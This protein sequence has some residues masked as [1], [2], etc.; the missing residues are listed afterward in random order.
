M[1]Q[2]YLEKS[3]LE[4]E[5]VE[6]IRQRTLRAQ[7]EFAALEKM[8]NENRKIHHKMKEEIRKMDQ[9]IAE[10]SSFIKKIKG[11]DPQQVAYGKTISTFW[12]TSDVPSGPLSGKIASYPS[13]ESLNE[14]PKEELTEAEY[15]YYD[16]KR[17]KLMGKMALANDVYMAHLQNFGQEDPKEKSQRFLYQFNEIGYQLHRQFD[18]VAERLKLPFEQPLMTYP[19]LGNL[20]DVIQ[21]EDM[22][23]KNREYF[24]EMAKEVKVKDEI[25]RKVLNNRL[26]IVKTPQEKDKTYL[27]YNEYRKESKRLLN[28]CEKMIEKREKG[29]DSLEL[30]QPEGVPEVKEIPKEKLDEKIK[31]IIGPPQ[32]V[33]PIG[34]NTLPPHY[35]REISRYE[36]PKLV[37]NKEREE[38]IEK[39]KEMTNEGMKGDK[40]EKSVEVDTELSWDHEGLK[41][42]PKVSKNKLDMSPKPPRIPRMLGTKTNAGHTSKEGCSAKERKINEGKYPEVLPKT[43]ESKEIPSRAKQNFGMDKGDKKFNEKLD[44]EKSSNPVDKKTARWIEEQNELMG[45]Q[46]EQGTDRDRKEGDVPTFSPSNSIKVLQ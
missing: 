5:E 43:N 2:A 21:Q 17:A 11:E 19:S 32:Y 35:S 44:L 24:Q 34:K 39:V 37:K 29:I 38:L 16:K 25:A 10:S 6:M 14:E 28:F 13:I 1:M 40:R 7:E 22:E 9:A 33:E 30:E 8:R 27:Q 26:T 46:R 31:E 41:P 20:M 18:I 12:D 42:I 45:K 23:D 3:K 36:P 4:S 15:E